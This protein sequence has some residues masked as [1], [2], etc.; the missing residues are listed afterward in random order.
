[1]S[2]TP[3][4][5]APKK[6]APKKEVEV[7]AKPAP[8]LPITLRI[9]TAD[10]YAYI[11]VP[12]FGSADDAFAEYQRLMAMVKGGEGLEPKEF[13]AILDEYLATGKIG[14]TADFDPGVFDRMN[15]D[16]QMIIQAIKRSRA[17]TNK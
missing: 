10:Q 11:E 2:E 4:K 6:R 14:E 16:Q 1:M 8:A 9:P 17:R 3:K 15:L 12:F 5:A 7:V 13:N